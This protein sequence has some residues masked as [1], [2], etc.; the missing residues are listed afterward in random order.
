[1]R[2]DQGVQTKRGRDVEPYLEVGSVSGAATIYG[3]RFKGIWE[4]FKA[5]TCQ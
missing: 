3:L 2:S 5:L 4:G 1:M